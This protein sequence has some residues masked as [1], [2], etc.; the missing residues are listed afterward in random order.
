[1]AVEAV[2]DGQ[3]AADVERVQ[4]GA[5]LLQ[6]AIHVDALGELVPVVGTVADAGVDEEVHE[7]QLELALLHHVAHVEGDDVLVAHAEAAGV[8]FE[9]GG[10]FRRD[11]DA[12]VARAGDGFVQRP[13]LAHV[14]DDGDGAHA[15]VRQA[16]D[17]PDVSLVLV[18]VAEDGGGARHFARPHQ[19]FDD[20]DVVRAA[21][22]QAHALLQHLGH[23]I[24][25][26]VALGAVEVFVRAVVVVL[27]ESLG[28]VLPCLV[29]LLADLR[30][31]HDAQR[32]AVLRDDLRQ[33]QIVP[34][35]QFVVELEFALR[36]VEG[37]LD[38]VDVT[39]LH[40]TARKGL[41]MGVKEGSART[42]RPRRRKSGH[43]TNSTSGPGTAQ[44]ARE[45]PGGWSTHISGKGRGRPKGPWPSWK[46]RS[47][48]DAGSSGWK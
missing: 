32:R 1:M 5:E 31:V 10:F 47:R 12:D 29:D 2:V 4:R 44:V 46:T 40:G 41:G 25:E 14:V 15:A 19:P 36:E 43:M 33:R 45:I 48:S 35:Q 27:L 22:L 18:A 30:E 8:E 3:S 20:I 17:V 9:L 34:R 16:A 11:A 24:A 6:V 13:Q 26:L 7:L 37:L 39:G 42:V 21:G 38:Q 28:E 23:H